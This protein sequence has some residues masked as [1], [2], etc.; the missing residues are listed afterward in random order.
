M[1][2]CEKC[3]DHHLKPYEC[4][5]G[6]RSPSKREKE[7]LNLIAEGRNN[8][9]IADKLE[10]SIHTVRAHLKTLYIKFDIDGTKYDKRLKLALLGQEQKEACDGT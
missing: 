5:H 10:L 9:S 7:V 3:S 1:S 2:W 4:P 6:D 8:K